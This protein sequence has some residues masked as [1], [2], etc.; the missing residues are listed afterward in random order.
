MA[1][2]KIAVFGGAFDPPHKGHAIV[3][4]HLLTLFDR[5][6]V[7]P[8]YKH[9]Y[10][11]KMAPYLHRQRMCET[12][13]QNEENIVVS[14]FEKHYHDLDGSYAILTKLSELHPTV[15]FNFVI[16]QDNANTVERWKNYQQLIKEFTFVVLPRAGYEETHNWYKNPPH[17][18]ISDLPVLPS[19]SS[20][21]IR[22]QLRKGKDAK[23][24]ST[25]V[26][27]YIKNNKL[28]HC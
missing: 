9:M 18:F 14:N 26:C 23:Y 22:E 27:R 8:A 25:A 21:I 3:A 19:I 5:V 15:A 24:L 2:T 20:T 11:K 12:L 10:D 6:W 13:F 7:M 28:Y 17:Q 4:R 1:I 16:G